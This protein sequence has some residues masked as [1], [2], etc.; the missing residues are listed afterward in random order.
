MNPS[1]AQGRLLRDILFDFVMKEDITCF[2][3]QEELTRETFSI[4]HKEPW[5]DSENPVDMFFDIENISYS[6]LSCNTRAAR[7]PKK[8]ATEG[9]KRVANNASRRVRRNAASQKERQAI[10]RSNYEKYKC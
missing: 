6:H 4:E 3:C 9:E 2:H 1:T 7:R 8:Y 5:L 10:R